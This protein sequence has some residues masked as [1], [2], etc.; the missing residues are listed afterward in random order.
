MPITQQTYTGAPIIR[1]SN[2]D[3]WEWRTIWG[4]DQEG[5]PNFGPWL[6]CAGQAFMKPYVE[7]G[8]WFSENGAPYSYSIDKGNL[9]RKLA[10]P[11]PTPRSDNSWWEWRGQSGKWYQIAESDLGEDERPAPRYRTNCSKRRRP[12]LKDAWEYKSVIGAWVVCPSYDVVVMDKGYAHAHAGSYNTWSNPPTLRRKVKKPAE[13]SHRVDHSHPSSTTTN[14]PS[15]VVLSAGQGPTVN[16]ETPMIYGTQ[17]PSTTIAV[18]HETKEDD[19]KEDDAKVQWP[20]DFVVEEAPPLGTR[21]WDALTE[22]EYL[23]L[24]PPRKLEDRDVYAALVWSK[25]SEKGASVD[26]VPYHA[27]TIVDPDPPEDPPTTRSVVMTCVALSL[28]NTVVWAWVGHTKGAEF[29]AWM[30]GT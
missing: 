11:T 8:Q 16:I 7:N 20:K 27:L 22:Q 4:R 23:L 25:D 5:G 2:L 10:P 9:R 24:S 15:T 21:M 13:E 29:L 26:E 18:T 17:G 14:T 30:F 28:L 3:N 1:D 19:V 12:P 6:S